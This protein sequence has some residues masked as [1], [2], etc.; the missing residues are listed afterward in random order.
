MVTEVDYEMMES[1]SQMWCE[2]ALRAY[3]HTDLCMW[4]ELSEK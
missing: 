4:T 2:K 3:S 1:Y